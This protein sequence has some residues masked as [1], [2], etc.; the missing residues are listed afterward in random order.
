MR[1]RMPDGADIMES[2][3]IAVFP[4]GLRIKRAVR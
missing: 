3:I 1:K 2:Q 4:K